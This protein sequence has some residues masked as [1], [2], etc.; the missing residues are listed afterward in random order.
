VD[1]AGTVELEEGWLQTRSLP[2]GLRVKAGKYLSDFGYVNRQ[3]PHQW[4][5]VDQNLPYLNL[6]GAHGLQDTGVQLTWLPKLPFYTLVG[7]ELAQ[8]DQERFGATLEEAERDE[9][10]LGGTES[11]P[12]LWTAFAKVAPD[13][14]DLHALQLGVSYAYN[15]QHQE[16]QTHTHAP[17]QEVVHEDGEVEVEVQGNGLDGN[18]ALWGLDLVYKRDGGGAHGHRDVRFQAEYLRAIKD[19]EIRSS[20]HPQALGARR[21]FTTDGLY[22]Q[23]LYGIAP[24]W[25]LGLRYDVLGLTNQ[26]SGGPQDSD[27]GSSDRWTL[28]L[29]WKLSELSLLRAQYARN[30]I[31]VEPGVR[32]RFDA[33]YLQFLVSM[34][35]HGAHSF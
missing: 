35:S 11:G 32:E 26:V 31:L 10:G 13:L 7:A 12:R 15:R 18:A 19:L 29:T 16:V 21:T 34:G 5:F 1:D 22:A 6:L 33:F 25:T 8:G 28:G 9:L 4:A 27:F 23:A 17:I 24:K 30:D 3:H 20:P 2:Y 14:G